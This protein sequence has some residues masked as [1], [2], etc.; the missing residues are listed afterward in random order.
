M[1]ND[2]QAKFLSFELTDLIIDKVAEYEHVGLPSDES[3][4]AACIRQAT[5]KSCSLVARSWQRRSRRYLF[6]SVCL[7]RRNLRKRE[8]FFKLLES[9]CST[10][11]PHVRRLELQ[12]NRS[13]T[14][15]K[16]ALWLNNRLPRLMALTAV[17]SL[18][19]LDG[20]F[21]LLSQR[22]TTQFFRSSPQLRSLEIRCV[23]FSTLSQ[24]THALSALPQLKTLYLYCF[25]F[26][27]TPQMDRASLSS[28][29]FGAALTSLLRQGHRRLN[30]NSV[31][32]HATPSTR[33]EQSEPP[34][35][36][37]PLPPP[38]LT[39]LGIHNYDGNEMG[40][41]L[42]WLS[43]RPSLETL[44]MATI[45]SSQSLPVAEYLRSLGPS[46]RHLII[47]FASSIGW[48]AFCRDVNLRYST[49]LHTIH[50]LISTYDLGFVQNGIH[51]PHI[52]YL[53]SQITHDN[54]REVRMEVYD[55]TI[56]DLDGLGWDAIEAILC[57]PNFSG[58]ERL[59]VL[60]RWRPDAEISQWVADRMPTVTAK[61]IIFVEK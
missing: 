27:P 25:R 23:D 6:Y 53:L 33:Q 61:G 38:N 15:P 30:L 4:T 31:P 44:A 59:R 12:E 10:I 48:N 46:L 29:S 40:D 5:L 20:Q 42:K 1:D 22:S 57:R 50:F 56:H 55:N 49:K 2:V 45:T 11:A 3:A 7:D 37:L 13:I 35:D 34:D 16:K 47:G 32:R 9:P 17:E 28:P 24:L 41:V 8:S 52:P 58:L 60:R 43:S 36:A 51:G 18:S 54:I 39:R 26:I 19:I 21:Q 14:K